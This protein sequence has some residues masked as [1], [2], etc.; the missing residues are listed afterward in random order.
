MDEDFSK[1]PEED[2]SP[3][4]PFLGV[5]F[6]NCRVYGRLYRNQEGTAYVGRCPKCGQQFRIAI[7]PGGTPQRFFQARC[8]T[9]NPTWSLFN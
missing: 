8:R 6:I 4:N 3:P 5:N 7:S 9:L 1:Q 2:T